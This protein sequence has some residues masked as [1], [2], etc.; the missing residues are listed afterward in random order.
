MGGYAYSDDD[1]VNGTDPTGQC[2]CLT[3]GG[4]EQKNPDTGVYGGGGGG[5]TD[6]YPV[7]DPG[8]SGSDPIVSVSPHVSVERSDP[9]LPEL[10]KAWNWETSVYGPAKGSGNELEAWV[11]ACAISPYA[12]VCTGQFGDQ[13]TRG[14]TLNYAVGEA[15]SDGDKLVVGGAGAS[16]AG[17]LIPNGGSGGTGPVKPYD[18]GTYKDLQAR[19][20]SGDD[21]DLHHVPQGALRAR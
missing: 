10:Q 16:I 1:P 14:I 15:F 4:T 13:L 3:D 19:S 12:G 6:P 11:R 7:T 21:I 17:F 5:E 8:T 2:P 18:V 9:R 20:P